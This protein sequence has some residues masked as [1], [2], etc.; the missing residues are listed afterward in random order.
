MDF[1]IEP[2]KKIPIIDRADVIVIGGGSAGVPAAIAAARNGAD[3]LIIEQSNCLG[4]TI[5]GG[6]M[7]RMDT[8]HAYWGKIPHEKRVARGLY[9]EILQQCRELGGVIE[10]YRLPVLEGQRAEEVKARGPRG[11]VALFKRDS[12]VVQGGLSESGV[13]ESNT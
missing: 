10:E 9:L 12:S 7:T 13:S 6:L 5:T 1:I 4:G 11:I 8:S 2:Q 3:V